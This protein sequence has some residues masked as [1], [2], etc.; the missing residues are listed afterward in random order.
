MRIT[1]VGSINLDLVATAPRLPAPGETV[2]G[3]I[4]ARHP[5]GKGA[6]QALA[7]EKLGAEVCL[8]GRVGDDA[9]GRFL[10]DAYARHRVATGHVRTVAGAPS[11]CASA[12]ITALAGVNVVSTS[13]SR[14]C[15]SVTTSWRWCCQQITRTRRR[16]WRHVRTATRDPHTGRRL[17]EEAPHPPPHHRRRRGW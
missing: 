3:A 11:A 6:N 9:D 8:I 16:P 14:S 10:L 1:V 5:G 12:L 7:A 4:L 2:T 17:G 13:S 15:W